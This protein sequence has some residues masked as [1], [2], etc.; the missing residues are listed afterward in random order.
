MKKI[1]KLLLLGLLGFVVLLVLAGWLAHEPLPLVQKRGAAAD[2][3]ARKVELAVNKAAWDSTRYV[4]W[5][6]RTG[7][8]YIWDKAE[9][10]VLV[11]WDDYEVLLHTPS[12]QG[13][14][15]RAGELL[16]AGPARDKALRKAWSQFANDSFWLCAPMKLFDPG[17]QRGIVVL[18]DGSEALLVSYTSGGVTPGDHYLWILEE[19]GLP[20][21]WK[22]WVSIIPVGGLEFA[23]TNWTPADGPRIARD[24]PGALFNVPI[25]DLSFPAY[26]PDNSPFAAW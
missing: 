25:L 22:M 17:T 2:E 12:L 18:E 13:K 15:R 19:S 5:A 4:S 20:K 1:L 3:L 11:K 7:T 21:A 16:A 24:H 9:N 26:T 6:F 23:W 8:S 10:Q 14:V